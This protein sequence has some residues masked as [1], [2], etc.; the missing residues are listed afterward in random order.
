MVTSLPDAR[1]DIERTHHS[2]DWRRR[3]YAQVHQ[4]GAKRVDP[5]QRE[6]AHA[7]LLGINVFPELKIVTACRISY[8]S[9]PIRLRP[10]I[11]RSF[12]W[13]SELGERTSHPR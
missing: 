2:A 12:A 4:P 13:S 7:D 10:R 6:P 8:T 3:R 5:P 9:A 11:S 1:E